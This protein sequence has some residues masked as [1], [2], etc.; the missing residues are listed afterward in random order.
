MLFQK[1]INIVLSN[2]ALYL[3]NLYRRRWWGFLMLFTERR[4]VEPDEVRLRLHRRRLPYVHR[5]T[6]PVR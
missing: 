6:R 3:D 5:L 4:I 2:S 1:S